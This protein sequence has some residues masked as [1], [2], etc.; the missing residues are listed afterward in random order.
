MSVILIDAH[1]A[2]TK[3]RIAGWT[4]YRVA[5]VVYLAAPALLLMATWFR[6]PVAI[7]AIGSLLYALAPLRQMQVARIGWWRVAACLALGMLFA[8]FSGTS[9]LV[10]SIPSFDLQKH[11]WIYYDLVSNPWPVFYEDGTYLR[12][13]LALY[14]IPAALAKLMPLLGTAIFVAWIGLGIALFLMLITAGANAWRFAV[15]VGIAATFGGLGF[16][17]VGLQDQWARGFIGIHI[18]SWTYLPYGWLIGSNAFSLGWCPQHAIGAWLAAALLYRFHDET[19]FQKASGGL[20]A[21]LLLW[22]P[23]AAVAFAAI[24]AALFAM[25]RVMFRTASSLNNI[26]AIIPVAAMFAYT[27]AD[28]GEVPMKIVLGTPDMVSFATKYI[29]FVAVE[30]A[31]LAVLVRLALGRPSRLLMVAVGLLLLLPC[32]FVGG[33]NDLMQRGSILPTT[34]LMLVA[35]EALL[36]GAGGHWRWAL[37]LAIVLCGLTGAEEAIRQNLH[38]TSGLNPN[39][40]IRNMPPGTVYPYVAHQTPVSRLLLHAPAP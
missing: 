18:A 10:E 27:T 35:I 8:A 24:S 16:L 3:E 39:Q 37:G 36:H 23:F 22:S 19:W 13:C 4:G 20:F 1:L 40:S 5:A 31:L 38:T 2:Q 25:Q 12:Y 26:V 33:G 28:A 29:V 6:P 14:V 7:L 11:R 15:I 21:C 9:P 34:I 32:L 17:A 30:F